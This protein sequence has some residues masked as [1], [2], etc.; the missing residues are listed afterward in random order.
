VT[1]RPSILFVNQHYWP[2]VAATGQI[3]SDLTEF[4]VAEGYEV[5][6]LCSRGGYEGGRL[7][8][9][10]R[11]IRRGVRVLRVASPGFGRRRH[12]GR[13]VDYAA[14]LA[15]VAARLASGPRWDLIVLLTTPSMLPVSGWVAGRIRGRRYAIWSMDIH[16]EIEVALGI[17][18]GA[19]A[20][21]LGPIDRASHERAEFVV[22]LGSCMKERLLAKG[23]P[24]PLIRTIPVWSRKDELEPLPRHDNELA[25][26]L[27]IGDEFVVMYSG[28]AGL[29][30]RFDEVLEAME[31]LE[32]DRGIEFVFIGGGPRKPE[33]LAGANGRRNFRYL[34]YQPRGELTRSLSLGDVHLLTMR[35][36]MAGLVVPVK[37]YGI[38]AAARPVVMVGP[39]DSD[40]ARTIEREEIG[41][42]IDPDALESDAAGALVETLQAL[43]R[44]PAER[45]RMGLRA[46]AAFLER[47]E[48]GAC[49]AIWERLIRET[50]T[51]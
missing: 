33:I 48:R 3:L 25:S 7:D 14:F 45:R 20:R 8:A 50:L 4:L 37:L 22:A 28:N 2:D 11:E 17:L 42:V 13:L 27:G 39:R 16:P 30:H 26:E 9:P 1:R 29:A 40:T 21:A 6:V 32:D 44:D 12:A 5:G 19:V 34:D 35:A 51:P 38:M 36:D 47:Y 10:D 18:P 41:R 46:R 49:C 23:V 31:R 15:Q 24:E 43:R